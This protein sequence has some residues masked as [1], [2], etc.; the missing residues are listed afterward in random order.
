[1][2]SAQVVPIDKEELKGRIESL[3]SDAEH[4]TFTALNAAVNGTYD[5]LKKH[6]ILANEFESEIVRLTKLL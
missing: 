3:K 1:M 4:H 5:D 2:H 6:R